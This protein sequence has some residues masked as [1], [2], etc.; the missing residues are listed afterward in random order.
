VLEDWLVD[1]ANSRGARIVTREGTKLVNGPDL[2]ELTNEELMI[3]LLLP[4]N[5]DRPQMLRAWRRS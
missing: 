2:N 1:I 5:R 4:Q 3:G